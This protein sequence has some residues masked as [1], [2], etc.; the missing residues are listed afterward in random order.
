MPY[1]SAGAEKSAV[2]GKNEQPI[3]ETSNKQCR[4]NK[5]RGNAPANKSRNEKSLKNVM[6]SRLSDGAGSRT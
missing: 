6:F 1:H 5:S 4:K 3:F 2:L